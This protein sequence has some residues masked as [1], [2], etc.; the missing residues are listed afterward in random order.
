MFFPLVSTP[1]AVEP[2]QSLS[3]FDDPLTANEVALPASTARSVDHAG[4]IA[5]GR[6]VQLSRLSS[7]IYEEAKIGGTLSPALRHMAG[8]T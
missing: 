4:T 6:P 3:S 7:D 2:G 1:A 5:S 8:S